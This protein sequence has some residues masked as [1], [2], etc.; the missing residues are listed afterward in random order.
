LQPHHVDLTRSDL[1]DEI[2]S[3]L[4]RTAFERGLDADVVR[5]EGGTH[6]NQVEGGWSWR[7]ATE[8]ALLTFLHSLPDGSKGMT[9]AEVALAIGRPGCDLAYVGRGLEET[10]RRAW[11][12]RREGDHYFFRTRA[13][14]N[15]R[16]QERLAEVQ[17]GEVRETLDDWIEAVYAGFSAFQVIPFPQD[18]TAI[19]DTADRVRLVIVHYDKE[20]GAVGGGDRLNVTKALFTQKGAHAGPRTYR[21]NLIFLL[22]ESTRIAGLKEAVRNLMAWERVRQDIETEQANLAQASGTDYQALKRLAQRGSS[23]VPAEFVAL[24]ND[25]ADVQEKFGVQEVNVRTKLLEAYRVLAFPKDESTDAQDLFTGGQGGPL[26]ECYRVDFGETP[27]ETITARTRRNNR[28]AVA[29]GPILQ[30]LRQHAKLAPEPEVEGALVLAP[31]VVRRRPLWLPDERRIATEEVWDRLRKEPELPIVLKP[32]DLFPTIRAGLTVTSDALW[33]YYNQVEKKV[34]TR[35]HASSLSP[36]LAA[37]HFLYDPAA[38][39]ADRIMPVATIAPQ[40]IW[41]HLWPRQGTDRAGSVTTRA[42]LEAAKASAHFPVMP[43][44]SVLWQGLQEGARENRWILYLRGPNLAIGAQEIHEWP[45]TPRLD[46]TTEVWNYQ[47]ALDQQIYPRPVVE[48]IA[49]APPVTPLT[50]RSRCWPGGVAELATEELERLGRVVWRDLTRPHLETVLREGVRQGAWAAWKKGADETFFVQGDIPE[51]AIQ[52]SPVWALVEPASPLV[53]ELDTLRPGRGPQPVT[54]AGPPREAL[55]HLWDDLSAFHHVQISE[56]TL[57][58]NDRDSF[59][60][61]LL[62]TWADRP[63][64]A[65]PH[66]SVVAN[67]QREVSSKQE[68]VS[69]GFEG[70]F[71]EVRAML[72]PV[73]PFRSQGELDVTIAVRLT[74]NPPLDCTDAT[75]ETYRTALMNANQGNIEVRVVPMCSRRAGGA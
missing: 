58:V 20:C 56:L 59:D 14:V 62:A 26:L 73:W 40:D 19:S 18:H 49:E 43:E 15:K 16:F 68:T 9:P 42:L 13:S 36:V 6:A 66:S 12:M 64:M 75:L 46:D 25:L 2:L 3:R 30:C 54:R 21:N 52:V 37:T 31:E 51:P 17:P 35:E 67:G 7:A 41:D 22:A 50:L 71:E 74:F 4:G 24:E 45:G 29:E 53:R 70:R 57:T 10:E 39:I 55:T 32:T 1:R 72:S 27:D 23:G 33:V 47:A 38:A 69:L 44:S 5:S 8:A 28:Q 60:N 65:Q 11:Y 34:Y 48:G 61:T 63:P